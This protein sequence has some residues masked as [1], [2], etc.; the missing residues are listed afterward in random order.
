MWA[1]DKRTF[2]KLRRLRDLSQAGMFRHL[3]ETFEAAIE[4]PTDPSPSEPGGESAETT[5]PPGA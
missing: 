1:R 2:T 5:P 4:L 3:I